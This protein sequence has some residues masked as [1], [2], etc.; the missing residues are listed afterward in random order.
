M[1]EWQHSLVTI[2]SWIE[3]DNQAHF[4]D[5]LASQFGNESEACR[6]DGGAGR[7]AV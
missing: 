6:D 2:I 4:V 1:S 5:A 7:E 3:Y